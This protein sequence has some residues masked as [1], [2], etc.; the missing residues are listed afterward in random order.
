M[1]DV[2]HDFNICIYAS[3]F[4]VWLPRP[5]ALWLSASPFIVEFIVFSFFGIKIPYRIGRPF[6]FFFFFFVQIQVGFC[7]VLQEKPKAVKW[8]RNVSKSKF[9]GENLIIGIFT[10][11]GTIVGAVISAV[12]TSIA[13]K[14]ERNLIKLKSKAERLGSQVISYWNLE[15]KY[16]EEVGSLTSKT[17]LTV[18]KE[19][20]LKVKNDEYER[21]KMTENDVKKLLEE[22]KD[23]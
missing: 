15:K 14:K 20:R 18:M 16:C 19:F 22:I 5:H 10:C 4:R 1:F 12:I 13:S 17:P 11:A 9:M 21:P 8:R 7:F 23:F 6:S 3:N 2:S